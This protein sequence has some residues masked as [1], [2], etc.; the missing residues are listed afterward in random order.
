LV[1]EV[2]VQAVLHQLVQMVLTLYFLQSLP[3]EVEEV[4]HQVAV[5]E[6]LEVVVEA[7]TD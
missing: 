1:V 5:V 3:L 4:V 6:T 2:L 7:V